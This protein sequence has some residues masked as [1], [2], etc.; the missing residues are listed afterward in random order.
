MIRSIKTV[1]CLVTGAV[2][3]IGATAASGVT[4]DSYSAIAAR[5][6]FDLKA[7]VLPPVFTNPPPPAANIKLT[8]ISSMLG[9][10]RALFLVSAAAQPGKPPGKEES[11]ILA[12][13][14]RQGVIE[15][16]EVNQK[17]GIARIRNDGNESVL[18]LDT[19]AKPASASAGG[20][21]PHPPFPTAAKA[22]IPL[23]RGSGPLAPNHAL[24]AG[25]NNGAATQP[26]EMSAEEKTILMEIERQR[27]QPLVDQGLY[28][29]MPG[30]PLLQK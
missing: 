12:E 8:G 7:P 20:A 29:P 21:P 28:P 14:E 18:A 11:Y 10:R 23:T 9:T 22:D 1:I 24:Y 30:S 2:L 15:V 16:L 27:T 6:V 26:P 5:N 17:A 25:V 13:G 19:T 3:A 4:H